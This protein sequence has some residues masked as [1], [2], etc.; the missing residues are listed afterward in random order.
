MEVEKTLV[1][2]QGVMVCGRDSERVC[3]ESSAQS[4]VCLC[5]A[6]PIGRRGVLA[7]AQVIKCPCWL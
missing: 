2:I 1:E 6:L 5:S 3:R 7:L 4:D